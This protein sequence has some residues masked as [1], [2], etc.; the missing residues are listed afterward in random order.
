V[1]SFVIVIVTNV[2]PSLGGGGH[3]VAQLVEA[4]RYKPEG[5]WFDSRFFYLHNPS[6]RPV[7]LCSTQPVTAMSTRSISCRVKAAGA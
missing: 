1:S 2:H 5:F 6:C 4:L 7:E 3:A